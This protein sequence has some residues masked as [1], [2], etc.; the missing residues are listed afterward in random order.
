MK[1]FL[2][3][4]ATALAVASPLA[5]GEGIRVGAEVQLPE[6]PGQGICGTPD[7]AFGAD[8]Y[9]VVWCDGWHGE[10]GAARIYA[11]RVGKSGKVLDPK[12]IEVAP[13]KAGVQTRPRVAF[14]GG[15]FLVVW[16][17]LRN[18][19]DYDVLAA[20]LSPEGKVL[21]A[22]PI[23]VAGGPGGQVSPDAASDGK[24]FAVVWQGP[25]DKKGAP[26]FYSFSAPVSA[27]G[28]T[29]KANQLMRWPKPR[30]AW[31]GQHYLVV[32]AQTINGMRIDASAR[33]VD[34]SFRYIVPSAGTYYNTQAIGGGKDG[35][36]VLAQR[37][38]PD[39]HGWGGYGAMRCYLVGPD[40]VLKAESLA[41]HKKDKAGNREKLPHWLDIGKSKKDGDPWPYGACAAAWDGKRYV[42]VWQRHHITKGVMF[43]NSD[44]IASRVDGFKPLDSAG[45]PVAASAEE[46]KKPALASDGAGKVLCAYEKYTKDGNVKICV[47]VLETR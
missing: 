37:S 8:V 24:G 28:A 2:A 21:D 31:N 42:A 32:S 35:W 14:G 20:R 10:G 19:K 13:C 46:E 6:G 12:A 1:R 29:G 16:Q 47:R 27:A 33:P 22:K 11:A 15:V 39:H 3:I 26:Y 25:V 9:L 44:L 30:L 43:T 38:Q 7:A 41:Q 17:D 23:V 34:K 5:A 36:L 18:E 40:A 45:V 4:L